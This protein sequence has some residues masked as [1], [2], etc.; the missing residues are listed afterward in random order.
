MVVAVSGDVSHPGVG[1]VAALLL[2]FQVA[3]LDARDGKVRDLKLY[4]H[5]ELLKGF[6]LG[7]FDGR[8]VEGG[9][10]HHFLVAY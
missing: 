10:K 8:Q 5:R 4:L 9:F 1:R 3:D 2:Y 6:P 7:T